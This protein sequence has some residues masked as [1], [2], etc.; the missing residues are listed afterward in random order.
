MLPAI[1]RTLIVAGACLRLV[2]A[3]PTVLAQDTPVFPHVRAVSGDGQA[4]IREAT[5]RSPTILALVDRLGQSDVVVYVRMQAFSSEALDGRLAVLSASGGIRYL[6]VELACGRPR[7]VQIA[8]LG[9]E[10][11]HAVEV[12]DEPSVVSGR[13]LASL[14]ARIGTETRTAVGELT[15][16][17]GA[18][19]DV[20]TRVRR[21]LLHPTGARSTEWNSR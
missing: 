4:F 20:A 13:T 11:H 12:A 7:V 1:R 9:H 15:F 18:A 5:E 8:T 17:T 10:L 3:A 16:E 19:R 2:V 6:L 14:Y 21:E